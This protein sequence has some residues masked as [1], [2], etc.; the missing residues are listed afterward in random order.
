[1]TSFE[2]KIN[3]EA[4]FTYWLQGLIK[5]SSSFQ[6]SANEFYLKK[7]GILNVDQSN[8]LDKLAVFLG[9]EGRGYF[10]L[11]DMYAGKTPKDENSLKEWNRISSPFRE[12]FEPIWIEQKSGLEFW[13]NILIAE[14]FSLSEKITKAQRFFRTSSDSFKF[15]VQLLIHW[16]KARASGHAQRNFPEILLLVVSSVDTNQKGRVLGTLLHESLHHLE[17][18]S[19]KTEDYILESYRKLIKPTKFEIEGQKWKSL[20]IETIIT[21]MAGARYNNY[22][23]K[24]FLED[25]KDLENDILELEEFDFRK[26]KVNPGFLIRKAS[27][28]VAPLTK[29]YLDSNK[30]LDQFYIDYIAKIWL[31]LGGVKIGF[32]TKIKSYFYDKYPA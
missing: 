15:E 1:M 8:A 11:Y 24:S 30:P 23:G 20:F 9:S 19:N 2:F 18:S 17:Y 32:L 27:S 12:S 5:W 10:W 22:F 16:D 26:H 7:I 4:N 3:K 14:S 13:K 29:E 21:S 31:K 25:E 28:L 6:K